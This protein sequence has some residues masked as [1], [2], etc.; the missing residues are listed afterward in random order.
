[1]FHAGMIRKSPPRTRINNL[2][3]CLLVDDTGWG[4]CFNKPMVNAGGSQNPYTLI[5]ASVNPLFGQGMLR[6]FKQRWAHRAA[7]V[8]L[9]TSLDETIKA[10]EDH[11]PNL[12]IID[13]DDQRINRLE[14]LNYFVSQELPMQV[15]LVSLKETGAVV[16]YDRKRMPSNQIDAWLFDTWAGGESC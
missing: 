8:R 2:S 1:M 7:I 15:V 12:V 10:I 14:F 6:L 4:Y 9:T 13:C 11:H 5:I 16:V 3:A